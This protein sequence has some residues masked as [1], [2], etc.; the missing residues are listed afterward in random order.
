MG[1]LDRLSAEQVGRQEGVERGRRGAL[2]VLVGPQAGEA[3]PRVLAAAAPRAATAR[4]QVLQ[5]HL[6][7]RLGRRLRED[8]RVAQH[9]IVQSRLG[10]WK[11]YG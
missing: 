7:L 10:L 5:D 1:G 9:A 6:H 8:R 4:A 11:R 2:V 3:A